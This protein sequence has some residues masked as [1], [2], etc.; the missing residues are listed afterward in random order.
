M[1]SLSLFGIASASAAHVG[2]AQTQYAHHYTVQKHAYKHVK[3]YKYATHKRNKFGSSYYYY[4][5][6][7]SYNKV[8]SSRY[9]STTNYYK[10]VNFSRYY[11]TTGYYKKVSSSRYYST[12][13]YYKKVRTSN[14][15]GINSLAS[16]LTRG[17]NSQYQK[18][19]NV[20]NWVK[21]NVRYQ[22]YYNTKYGANGALRYRAGNCADQA[23]LVVDLAR[24]AG[25]NAR[26]VHANAQFRSGHVYGHYWA[27]IQV[28]GKW[29]TADTTSKRNSF[30]APRNWNSARILGVSNQI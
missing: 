12:T 14:S 6:T 21:N 28:N 5:K 18:G 20:F 2:T 4:A 13:G 3:Y 29:I 1:A 7:G 11:T 26:Y 19:A 22:F 30:G 8:S 27:Q 9:Y 15:A 16:S 10:K 24:S 25:L 17:T 23:H